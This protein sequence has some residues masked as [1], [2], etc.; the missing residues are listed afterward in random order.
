MAKWTLNGRSLGG[1]EYV[2][3][4]PPPAGFSVPPRG[5][6]HPFIQLVYYAQS[7]VIGRSQVLSHLL[8]REG[9]SSTVRAGESVF[10]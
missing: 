2:Q 10:C 9:K 5:L 4:P 8:F 7:L 6:L 1:K 3:V